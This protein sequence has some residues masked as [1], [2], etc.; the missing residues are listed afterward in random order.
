MNY[1]SIIIIIFFYTSHIVAEET[2]YMCPYPH[3]DNPDD[4]ALVTID[5]ENNI[6]GW[7]NENPILH[8]FGNFVMWSHVFD[9]GIQ[10]YIFN[11]RQEVLWQSVI[12]IYETFNNNSNISHLNRYQCRKI[13]N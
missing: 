4:Y 1:F 7:G 3:N 10:S 6:I 9:K 11:K 8:R 13:E 5:I 2:K 12:S